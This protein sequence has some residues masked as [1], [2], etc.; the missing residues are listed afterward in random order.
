MGLFS[1]LAVTLA[2]QAPAPFQTQNATSNAP[3]QPVVIQRL[4]TTNPIRLGGVFTMGL[5][6]NAA[7][8]EE[9][10]AQGIPLGAKNQE[11]LAINTDLVALDAGTLT[12]KVFPAIRA[13]NAVFTPLLLVY[14]STLY[15]TNHRGNVGGWQPH[16]K[17]WTLRRASGSEVPHP[18]AGA[19]WMDF[20]SK[21]WGMHFRDQ[22]LNLIQ[23][24]GAMGV[25]A[26]ELPVGNTFVDEPLEKYKKPADRAI[27]TLDW[28]QSARARGRYFMVPSSLGFELLSPVTTP[29]PVPGT[30]RPDLSGRLW[31]LYAPYLDGV[32]GEGWLYPY[33]S[34]QPLPEKVWEMQLQAA[35]RLARTGQIF[36]AAYSYSNDE[37]LEFGLASYLLVSHKQGR[38]VF[39]P[40]P[41]MPYLRRDAGYSLAVM[42]QVVAAKSGFFNVEL[43]FALQER[44]QIKVNKPLGS[45]QTGGAFVWRRAF[46]KGIVYVN[47]DEQMVA[48]IDLGGEMKR[49][50]GEIVRR[51]RL[52]PMH[53][54]IL[55]YLSDKEKAEREGKFGEQKR[56]SER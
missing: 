16:M 24:Y 1:A 19:H 54:V 31:D 2:L 50:N 55:T 56:A 40:M 43:S 17:N 7:L 34:D 15:E 25:V 36:I 47:S 18:D 22:V 8:F 12:P 30:E 4:R 53:G 6:D 37:D 29:A 13:I 41:V 32:W 26:S 23:N 20:G 52:D 35:D 33:W 28:L 11:W 10:A 27:A 38:F 14:A 21:D 48:E 5:S 44:H 49:C 42:K 39:Q 46:D 51:V 9:S 3:Q 45:T